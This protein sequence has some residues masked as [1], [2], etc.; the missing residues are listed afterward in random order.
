MNWPKGHS[1]R[2]T[3][4]TNQIAIGL[5]IVIVAAICGDLFVTGGDNLIFLGKKFD[6]FLEWIAFWR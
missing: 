3:F 2:I 6:E 1:L 5:G 4:M